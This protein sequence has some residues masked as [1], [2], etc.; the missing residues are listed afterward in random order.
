MLKRNH[1]IPINDKS[2]FVLVLTCCLIHFDGIDEA[3]SD[4]LD[5]VPFGVVPRR[6][7]QALGIVQSLYF[8]TSCFHNLSVGRRPALLT[9]NMWGV[10]SSGSGSSGGSRACGRAGGCEGNISLSNTT[11]R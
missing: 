9:V 6:P 2:R 8:L 10:S 1:L 7:L 11:I 5:V 4:R 3:S